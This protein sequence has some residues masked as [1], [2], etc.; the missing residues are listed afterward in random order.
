MSRA[1]IEIEDM[2]TVGD[3]ADKLMI[4]TTKLITELMKNGIMMTVNER[5]DFDTAQ[6]ITGELN[7]PDIELVR[8]KD[9]ESAIN[10]KKSV[11]VSESAEARPP[12]VAVMGHVD[13]GKTTL[14]DAIR[15]VSVAKQEAGGITQHISAY[16]VDHKGK[17]ITFLD[18]PGHEAFASL[19]EHGAQLT[20]LAV[21]VIAAD[22]G[23]KPQTLEA[24]RFA[25]KS[26]VKMIFALNK[27]DKP[28]INIDRIKQ[29]LAEQNLMPE[30]WGG[31]TIIV[32]VSAKS[33]EGVD[34]LIEMITL[35]A[36]VEE[37]K[38]DVNVPASGLIIESHMEKGLGSVVI[39]L[40]QA[41][42]LKSGQYMVVG[43]IYG[44]VRSLESTGG[45]IIDS[46]GPSTPVRLTG[47]KSL[48]EFGQEFSVVACEKD[49]KKIIE[50][51]QRNTKGNG[52]S[53]VSTS[54]QLLRMINRNIEVSE[55]RVI[56]K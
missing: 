49:A 52:K 30:D 27:I 24:I 19:R 11:T 34:K 5:V 1:K 48:P 46:A 21:I 22:D 45:N 50:E 10:V 13:H 31:D 12:V 44:K 9:K 42:T 20:D 23:I 15:G 26:G 7:L 6:I 41:G 17:K 4:P 47:F 36:E 8:T 16:Q 53:G 55:L 33:K 35:V 18:T 56:I 39:A 54:S 29:Q 28:D 25:Q 51:L 38:A 37:L 43:S 14:L 3:L 32:P 2:I 40:V